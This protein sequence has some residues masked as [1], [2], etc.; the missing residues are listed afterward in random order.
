MNSQSPPVLLIVDDD[1]TARQVAQAILSHEN[2]AFRHASG[3]EAALD[4]IAQ[5]EPDVVLLDV[6]MPGI[7][8]FEVCQRIRQFAT[9]AYLPIM[10]ITALDSP[11]DL[12][13]GLNAGAD[14]FISKPVPRVELR[15]RVRSML[16]IR[17]QHLELVE[18]ARLLEELNNQREDL[19]R[20]VVHD[21][22][23][24]VTA[25]QLASS[26]LLANVHNSDEERVN[27]LRLIRKES[28]RVGNYLEEMLLLARQEE[29][30]LSL[31]FAHVSLIEVAHATVN[32][33]TPLARARG[34]T[35]RA[36]ARKGAKTEVLGDPA[37]LR[38]VI[39]NLLTN[40][41][42]FSPSDT[43]VDV[44]IGR[45][46]SNVTL[47]VVDEGPGVPDEMRAR[48][49]EKFEIVKMRAAGGPQTGLGL[50]FCRTVV[51]A[52]GGTISCLPRK[53]RGS[54]LH[55]T[56]PAAA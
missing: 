30:R 27:D 32:A 5:E 12:A 18:Q 19:V 6:M 37:L 49:F 24:P 13:R 38:R 25:I 46:G 33:V 16:R 26:A 29:G 39:D 52:H 48:I 54:R 21:L 34:V 36:M 10:M 9:R 17:R 2:Y 42:K 31:S 1:P 4:Q 53:G 15:A 23:S 40:A 8:G 11:K 55:V 56:F 14:D 35:I 45:E 22:R 43:T 41:I 3:G 50:P 47:D 20:M 44:I 7:D 51:E 28:R